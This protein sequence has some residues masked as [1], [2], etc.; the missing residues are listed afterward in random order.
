MF[1]GITTL[2]FEEDGDTLTG[3]YSKE[4][5]HVDFSNKIKIS[6]DSTIYV[7]LTKIESQMQL[8]LA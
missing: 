3:M 6:D 8:S 7:W 5:E 1:A 4:G 2:S